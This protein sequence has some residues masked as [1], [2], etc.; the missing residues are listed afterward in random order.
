MVGIAAGSGSYSQTLRGMGAANAGG[1][2][3]PP[4]LGWTHAW[5]ATSAAVTHAARAWRL[6][7]APPGPLSSPPRLA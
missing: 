5:P 7:G 1:V 4:E 6:I 2:D 3:A